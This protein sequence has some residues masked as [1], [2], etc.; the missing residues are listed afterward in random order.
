MSHASAALKQAVLKTHC[1]TP[2]CSP[3]VGGPA[4][5]TDQSA[6]D[7]VPRCGLL[8]WRR[9]PDVRCGH[10][11]CRRLQ[12]VNLVCSGVHAWRGCGYANPRTTPSVAHGGCGWCGLRCP[13]LPDPPSARRAAGLAKPATERERRLIARVEHG[14]LEWASGNAEVGR[15]ELVGRARVANAWHSVGMRLVRLM[16]GNSSAVG[17]MAMGWLLRRLRLGRLR[18]AVAVMAS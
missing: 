18:A 3:P 4:L 6:Q 10:R 17:A 5:P 16:H 1:S 2:P 13:R 9:S 8:R 15:A 11:A 7:A 12:Q 14:E